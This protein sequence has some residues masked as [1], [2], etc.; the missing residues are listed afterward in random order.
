MEMSVLYPKFFD[1]A[2]REALAGSKVLLVGVGGLGSPAA[3]ALAATGVGVIGL[4]D[5]DRVEI[6]N[7]QRQI[8]HRTSDLGDPKTKSGRRRLSV[9]NPGL[10]AV[11]HD[12]RVDDRSAA[13]LFREY[14]LI[15]DGSD[16]FPTRYVCSDAAFQTGKP[17][18]H[19]S[20][21]R[22]EG[23]LSV[24]HPGR[25][26]CYRCLFPEPPPPGA[27]P[28]CAQAGVLGALPGLVGSLMALEAVKT[29]LGRSSLA[30]RLLLYDALSMEFSVISLRRRE[31]CRVCGHEPAVAGP[32]NS[33]CE[34]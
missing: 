28:S 30:G 3:L 19:G 10:R 13:G 18:V 7:L 29:L 16:N 33:N 5:A 23:R 20:I 6:S 31:G 25:G 22:F 4:C 26:P 12:V 27:V 14:D 8:L 21:Y 1:D 24:F 2:D 17:L 11:E 15:I 32:E 9:M 34:R